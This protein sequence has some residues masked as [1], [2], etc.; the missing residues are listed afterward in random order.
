MDR[1]DT[2]HDATTNSHWPTVYRQLAARAPGRLACSMFTA[3]L[4]AAAAHLARPQYTLLPHN[5]TRGTAAGRRGG[6]V[7]SPARR[8]LSAAALSRV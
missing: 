6:A 7:P 1:R 5:M 3:E 8:H 2:V 4:M